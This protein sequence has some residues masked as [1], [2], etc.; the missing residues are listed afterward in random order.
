MDDNLG[1][2]GSGG[3]DLNTWEQEEVEEWM[4]TWEQVE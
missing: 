4:K 1:A 2:G 3:T